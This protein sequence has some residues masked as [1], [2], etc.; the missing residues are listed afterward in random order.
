MQ[1]GS[2]YNGGKSFYVD[3]SDVE[4]KINFLRG[5]MSREKFEHLLYRTFRET[6]NMSKTLIADEV[7]KDYAVPKYYV[8]RSIRRYSLTFGGAQPVTCVIPLSA[9]KGIIG[10]RF[11]VRRPAT[12]RATG[13]INTDILRSETS[14]LPAHLPAHL[15]GNRPF[16]AGGE[17]TDG[18]VFARRYRTRLPIIRVV[19]VAS[20]QMPLNQSD[21]KVQDA[22]LEYTG[23][24]LEHNF[25]YMMGAG[26]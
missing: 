7:V 21:E 14:T 4:Q 26:K 9:E 15:G 3:M 24:R 18:L 17:N 13:V 1:G 8:R 2:Y 20:P 11:R 10:G 6:A 22:L 12:A 19:G 25:D 16:V 23:D 5:I